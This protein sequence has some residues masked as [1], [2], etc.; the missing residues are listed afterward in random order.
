LIARAGEADERV[1]REVEA[2]L[3]DSH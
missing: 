3:L 2:A 1:L